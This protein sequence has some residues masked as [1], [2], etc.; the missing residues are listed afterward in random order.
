MK[1]LRHAFHLI[2]AALNYLDNCCTLITDDVDENIPLITFRENVKSG[3]DAKK[4]LLKGKKKK[5]KEKKS[6]ENKHPWDIAQEVIIEQS[7]ASLAI[8]WNAIPHETLFDEQ[9]LRVL[10]AVEELTDIAPLKDACPKTF[11]K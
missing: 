8:K 1:S 5:G 6:T 11:M 9:F 4:N 7:Q 10:H 3:K 2:L